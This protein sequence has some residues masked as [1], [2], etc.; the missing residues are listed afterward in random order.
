MN[1]PQAPL[2][3]RCYVITSGVGREAVDAAAAAAAAGAGLIQVRPKPVDRVLST[4]EVLD[5][6]LAV[7]R[8]AHAAN[9]VTRVVLDDRADVAYAAELAEP[10][11]VHG[12][13][14][15]QDDLPV[16]AARALLGPGAIIG[17]TT[18]TLALVERAN[19]VADAI[20]YI[21]AGPFRPTPTKDSGRQPLGIEGYPPLV[22]LS[23][24]P[25][26]AIGDIGVAD[27]S[28]L[29]GTGIAGVAVVR[30]VMGAADPGA[31][32]RDILAAFAAGRSVS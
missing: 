3:L 24:V 8:V 20:D 4:R 1:E 16:R 30:A 9:P 7:A 10:G 28:A 11:L 18:G 31:V 17:V 13:H 5:F 21:G 6:T 22:A 2:D 14:L 32:V 29:S 23:R 15:G 27:V 12:V 25:I 26:V 19:E